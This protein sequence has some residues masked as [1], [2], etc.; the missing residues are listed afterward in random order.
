MNKILYKNDT[1]NTPFN[2]TKDWE[3]SNTFNF[4]CVL[5]E[6]SGSPIA[7][8]FIDYKNLLPEINTHCNIALEQ[9]KSD[10][11]LH[12]MGKYSDGIFY[13]E[14]EEINI[15]GTFKRLVYNQIENLFYNDYR[16]PT[17]MWGMENLD[18]ENSKTE[19]FLT[20]EF[21][22]L[23]VPNLIFGEKII[24]KT[25]KIYDSS[26]DNNYII[27][28]DGYGNLFAQKNLFTRHQEIGDF[29]NNF[30]IG[31]SPICD[32]YFSFSTSSYW[33]ADEVN[34]ENKFRIWELA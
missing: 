8:E 5:T 23:D 34:W 21:K 13:P 1:Q 11:I 33:S 22:L 2:V 14:S 31:V 26:Q 32:A 30:E 15:D 6:H 19:K 12:R 29:K 18:F 4:D 17:K 25:I 10:K 24:E 20:D 27:A 9:Q 28:D 7:L 3:L 16:D